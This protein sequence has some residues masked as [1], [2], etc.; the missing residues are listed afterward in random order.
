MKFMEAALA[1]AAGLA[2]AGAAKASV[3][4]TDTG[5]SQNAGYIDFR[6]PPREIITYHYASQGVTFL[7]DQRQLLVSG[8]ADVWSN[9]PGFS[10]EY[11]QTYDLPRYHDFYGSW[12]INFSAPVTRAGAWFAFEAHSDPGSPLASLWAFLDGVPVDTI[13]V[14]AY[15]PRFIGFDAPMFNELRVT[16]VLGRDFIMDGLRFEPYVASVPEPG[17]WALMILGF[18]LAGAGLRRRTAQRL[19]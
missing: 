5:F 1:V 6:M 16:N 19:A 9:G 15:G 8:Y 13:D 3:F 10:G 2:L 17:A 14:F 7:G 12:S 11:L 18:G 4:Y